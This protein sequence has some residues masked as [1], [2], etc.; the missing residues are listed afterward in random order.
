MGQSAPTQS[1]A[2]EPLAPPGVVAE[3]LPLPEADAPVLGD[4]GVLVLPPLPVE[5]PAD[6][7]LPLCAQAAASMAAVTASP[8][9]FKVMWNL[10]G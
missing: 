7:L 3:A 4:P 8:I 5:A 6:V 10:Q 9:A 2:L 1:E